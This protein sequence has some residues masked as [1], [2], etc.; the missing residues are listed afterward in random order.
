[1]KKIRYP[2]NFNLKRHMDKDQD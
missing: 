2:A 1:M